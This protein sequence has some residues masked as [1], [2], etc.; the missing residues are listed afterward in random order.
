MPYLKLCEARVADGAGCGS[1]S[2]PGRRGT[3]H[4][5]RHLNCGCLLCRQPRSTCH[6]NLRASTSFH[7]TTDVTLP[8]HRAPLD[9]FSVRFHAPHLAKLTADCWWGEWG[10]RRWAEQRAACC[11]PG[12]APHCLQQGK[13]TPRERRHHFQGGCFRRRPSV[14]CLSVALQ[15]S[16]WGEYFWTSRLGSSRTRVS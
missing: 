11:S 16:Q 4:R 10:T 6:A 1:T 2:D 9:V 12:A 7:H 14:R 5:A 3:S 15:L 8:N 13:A